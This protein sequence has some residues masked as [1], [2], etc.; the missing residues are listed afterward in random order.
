MNPSENRMP[1]IFMHSSKDPREGGI[2]G[3]ASSSSVSFRRPSSRP[4]VANT[5]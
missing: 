1:L 5:L 2:A 4:P 3:A